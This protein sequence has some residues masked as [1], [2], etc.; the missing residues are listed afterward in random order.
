MTSDT[1]DP[2]LLPAGDD[3]PPEFPYEGEYDVPVEVLDRFNAAQAEFW[4]AFDDLHE[5]ARRVTTKRHHK[6]G[7]KGVS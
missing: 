3:D 4:S 5:K 2:I 6:G 1:W 7:V